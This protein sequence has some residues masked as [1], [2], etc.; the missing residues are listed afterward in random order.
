MAF[1]MKWV[2]LPDARLLCDSFHLPNL[3]PKPCGRVLSLGGEVSCRN[4]AIEERHL[5]FLVSNLSLCMEGSDQLP[6]VGT[7]TRL[8]RYVN[9]DILHFL[10]IRLSLSC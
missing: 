10:A 9:L 1:G 5:G 6:K 7:K 2:A 8:N 3:K 4:F